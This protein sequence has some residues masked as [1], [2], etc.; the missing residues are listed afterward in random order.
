MKYYQFQ[1]KIENFPYFSLKDLELIL[2]TKL[3]KSLKNQL[4]IWEKKKYLIRI[5]KSLYLLSRPDILNNLEPMFLA[6]KL[7]DP[8][9][10]SLEYALSLYG[11]LPEIASNVTS[12]TTK[13]T[14]KF[15]T[16]L[17]NFVFRNIKFE[18]FAGYENKKCFFTSYNIATPEK[19]LVDYIYLNKKQMKTEKSFWQSLRINLDQKFDLEKMLFYGKLL[20]S[21]KTDLLLN[22]FKKYAQSEFY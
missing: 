6:S 21:K 8:S 16:P 4:S 2:K 17:G 11:I 15:K 3:N 7:Y 20:K 9:Y 14:A 1:K 19:A 13:K 10:V 22:S 12:I 18:G 5:K